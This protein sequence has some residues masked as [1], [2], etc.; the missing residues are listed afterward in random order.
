MKDT[1]ESFLPSF[2]KIKHSSKGID[3]SGLGN[4]N[5]FGSCREVG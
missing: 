3:L 5:T 2:T 4:A 1:R